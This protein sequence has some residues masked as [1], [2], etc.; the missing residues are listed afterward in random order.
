MDNESEVLRLLEENGG[1]LTTKN[2]REK[3]VSN[4]VLYRMAEQGKIERAAHGLYI[5]TD[6]IPDAF[7]LAQ[8][9][10]PKGIFSH[11]TALYLHGLCDR[12]PIRL[13]MTIPSGSGS[14][15]LKDNSL[16]FFYCRPKLANQYTELLQTPSGRS[17]IAYNKERT[18]C[19]CLRQID[20]LDHDKVLSAVKQ[21]LTSA[22]CDHAKLLACAQ[23]F[24]VDK[25]VHNYMDMLL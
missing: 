6:V 23:V 25:E 16:K 1:Y 19:D 21:Y 15:A 24:K 12:F 20:K 22:G 4:I 17:V 13:T 2:A 7:V 18:L 9:R 3:D 11:E 5:S 10:C 8:Y 14:R